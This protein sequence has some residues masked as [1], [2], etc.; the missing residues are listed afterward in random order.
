MAHSRAIPARRRGVYGDLCWAMLVGLP[1]FL[2]YA[3][4]VLSLED[5]L[6]PLS[7]PTRSAFLQPSSLYRKQA[8]LCSDMFLAE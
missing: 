3:L 2:W 8:T 6:S 5:F 1:A 4:A 7:N